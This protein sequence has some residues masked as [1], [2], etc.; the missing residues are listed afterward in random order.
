MRARE[1]TALRRM[2]RLFTSGVRPMSASCRRLCTLPSDSAE[3]V[4]DNAGRAKLFAKTLTPLVHVGNL[5][6]ACA[7]VPCCR[8]AASKP[9]L[10]GTHQHTPC[11]K[12]TQSCAKTILWTQPLRELVAACVMWLS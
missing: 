12:H 7:T 3:T 1:F 4:L 5:F 11:N 2:R 8:R 9:P 10:W 6:V